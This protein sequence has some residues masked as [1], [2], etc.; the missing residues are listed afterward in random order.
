MSRHYLPYIS[1][2]LPSIFPLSPLYLPC[3]LSELDGVSVVGEDLPEGEAPPRALHRESRL[4][5]LGARAGHIS[6]LHLPY[7]SPTSPLS[8]PARCSRGAHLSPTSPLHLPH[9]SPISACSVLARGRRV[10]RRRSTG[11]RVRRARQ[12]RG[13]GE[14]GR[15]GERWGETGRYGK[16]WRA[17]CAVGAR[18]RARSRVRVRVRV[19]VRV[20]VRVRLGLGLGPG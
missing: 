4:R 20:R 3:L 17:S 1:L 14:M 6:P 5:L 10:R 7:I 15:Y 9:I 16:R 13:Q 8:P 18:A 12:L 19:K 11:A 2:Y